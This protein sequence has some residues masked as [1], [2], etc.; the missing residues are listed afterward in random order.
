MTNYDCISHGQ[1]TRT[2]R[3]SANLANDNPRLRVL[4]GLNALINPFG[5]KV[6]GGGGGAGGGGSLVL[7][8]LAASSQVV[9]IRQNI[10]CRGC[11]YLVMANENIQIKPNRESRQ[12]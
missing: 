11:P 5:A 6:G 3:Q 4:K 2:S 12:Q 8:S 1:R 7:D 9:K 10:F